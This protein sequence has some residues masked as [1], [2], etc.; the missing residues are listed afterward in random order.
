MEKENKIW[1][2]RNKS[3]F[4]MRVGLFYDKPIY[5]SGVFACTSKRNSFIAEIRIGDFKNIFGWTPR[6][7]TCKLHELR[8]SKALAD[9]KEKD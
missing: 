6:K 4:D 3:L 8:F 7:G 5:Q 9:Y 1:V 2:A